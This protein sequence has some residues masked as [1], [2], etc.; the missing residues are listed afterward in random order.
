[1]F[2]HVSCI[3]TFEIGAGADCIAC[4]VGCGE[5]GGGESSGAALGDGWNAA[6]ACAICTGAA[7]SARG[8][9]NRIATAR[10]AAR[11][12]AT[13]AVAEAS[14]ALRVKSEPPCGCDL[15][16]AGLWA[17]RAVCRA[18]V[19]RSDR[20]PSGGCRIVRTPNVVAD[21]A[22]CSEKS[23]TATIRTAELLAVEL[24]RHR[25][26]RRHRRWFARE[27]RAIGE[28]VPGR[29]LRIDGHRVAALSAQSR[30]G[31]TSRQAKARTAQKETFHSR[32][33]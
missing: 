33:R 5:A 25:R 31:P 11:D 27:S 10:T 8:Q 9:R 13:G 6:G 1:M 22:N 26:A 32:L 18:I 14:V 30:S 17:A 12:R 3:A 28:R 24:P 29:R 23:C 20:E 19:E 15:R 4:S 16:P 7:D 2:R 21:S